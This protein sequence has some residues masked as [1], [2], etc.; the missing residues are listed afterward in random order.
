MTTANREKTTVQLMS[1]RSSA[2][3]AFPFSKDIGPAGARRKS[4]GLRLFNAA[5]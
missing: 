3:R 5:D 4:L 1:S 2:N